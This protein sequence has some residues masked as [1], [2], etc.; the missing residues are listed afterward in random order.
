VPRK[1]VE[2]LPAS[3]PMIDHELAD[4][5]PAKAQGWRVELL[6]PDGLLSPNDQPPARRSLLRVGTQR[7][8][9]LSCSV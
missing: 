4:Q 2:R 3:P 1:Q 6:G 5:L 9:H 7:R 8:E